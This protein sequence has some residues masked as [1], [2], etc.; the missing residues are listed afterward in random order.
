MHQKR[1]KIPRAW[2]VARKGTK[3][4]AI[5]SHAKTKAIPLLF[6]LRDI[7]KIAKTREEARHFVLNGDVKINNKIRKDETFP[8][9]VF[10]VVNLEKIKKNYRLVF[11]NKKFSLKEISDKEAEKKIV[12]ISGGKILGKNK[13]QMNLVDGINFIVKEKFNVNDSAVVNTK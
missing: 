5:A 6:I 3:Y 1:S 7:L 4:L 10:D 11:V 12:K 2:P 13:V 8:V 9:Q